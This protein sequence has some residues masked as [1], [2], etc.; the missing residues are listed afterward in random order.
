MLIMVN[1]LFHKYI[2]TILR[3]LHD[4]KNTLLQAVNYSGI[5][6]FPWKQRVSFA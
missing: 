2:H 5:R 6:Y 3:M 4:L 1:K